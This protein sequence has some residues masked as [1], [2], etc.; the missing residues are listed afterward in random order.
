MHKKPR[1]VIQDAPWLKLT[2]KI[3]GL[4]MEVHNELGPG[5]REATYHNAMAA[6]FQ[7][8]G[9]AFEDEPYIPIALEDGTVVGGNRPD[10]VAEE[11]VI[12]ELKARS[13]LM[14]RDDMAQVI[15]YFAALPHCAVALFVNFGRPRLEYRRLLPPKKVKAFQREK[16][17]K[18]PR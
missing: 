3:I 9:L 1:E 17:G 6:K 7:A 2:Y 11:M 15:G 13:H 18:L 5:H 10:L 8:A 4:A 16:W 14:T 12:V